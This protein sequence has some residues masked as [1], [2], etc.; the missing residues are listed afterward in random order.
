[1]G[2]GSRSGTSQTGGRLALDLQGGAGFARQTVVAGSGTLAVSAPGS[3]VCKL[4]GW[5]KPASGD[6]QV[7]RG[8]VI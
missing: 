4:Y 1:M 2:R 3:S 6:G 8:G 5:E 7:G